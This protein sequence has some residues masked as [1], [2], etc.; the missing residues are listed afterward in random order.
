MILSVKPLSIAG[1]RL[2]PSYGP[3]SA[4]IA[5]A[6]GR[7]LWRMMTRCSLVEF[8]SLGFRARPK[9]PNNTCNPKPYKIVGFD[10]FVA[11][12]SGITEHLKPEDP[13]PKAVGLRIPRRLF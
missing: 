5:R 3:G 13:K 10:P 6:C 11:L 2:K 7:W 1:M 4:A 8:G 12:L 9:D